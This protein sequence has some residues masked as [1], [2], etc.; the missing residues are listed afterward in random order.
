MKKAVLIL[1]TIFISISSCKKDDP[2]YDI[3][4]IQSNSYNANKNKLKSPFQYISI[5]YANV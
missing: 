2:I 4:H 1:G 3:N 5:L